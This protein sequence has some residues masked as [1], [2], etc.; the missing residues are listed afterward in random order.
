LIKKQNN[1]FSIIILSIIRIEPTLAATRAIIL[2]ERLDVAGL[3]DLALKISKYSISIPGADF[4]KDVI[5]VF[6]CR[7]LL[8]L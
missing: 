4:K 1:Y 2:P 8:V 6:N 7:I 3:K 5:S